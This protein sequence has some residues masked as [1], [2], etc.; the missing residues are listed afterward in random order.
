MKY[1]RPDYIET[2]HDSFKKYF[3]E[4]LF[5]N[6]PY[7]PT[8][9]EAN[10][11][12]LFNVFQADVKDSIMIVE[13]DKNGKIK[14]KIREFTKENYH[15]LFNY[16]HWKKLSDETKIVT[17]YWYYEEICSDLKIFSPKFY[18][19]AGLIKNAA[20]YYEPN[21]NEFVFDLHYKED[22]DISAYKLLEIIA[23]EL[24]HAEFFAKEQKEYLSKYNDK[25]YFSYPDE[26]DYNLDDDYDKFCYYYD[27]CFYFMQPTELAS[28]NYGFKKA[29]EI[30]DETNYIS[31]KKGDETQNKVKTSTSLVDLSFFRVES[32]DRK[33]Y[34]QFFKYVL[35]GN[36][37]EQAD[38][39]YLKNEFFE[40][41]N[42]L[43]ENIYA[44]DPD[45]VVKKDKITSESNIEQVHKLIEEYNETLKNLYALNKEIEK[46]KKELFKKY[47]Q[48]VADE[49]IELYKN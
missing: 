36:F 33:M 29:K 4:E 24:K 48:M 18:F 20:G 3:D 45:V 6:L 14:Q 49:K 43:V 42:I 21:K 15:E 25:N 22:G 10:D 9:S 26:S 47:K 5:K 11:F 28:F 31:I 34:K 46:D 2:L 39:H 12:L 7:P 40:D 44:L 41:V 8:L 17:L 30:F 35:D 23:H 13:K 19:L 32:S 27:L 38:K 16:K 37:K 1:R